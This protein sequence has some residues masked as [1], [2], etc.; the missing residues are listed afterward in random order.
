M[1]ITQSQRFLPE[2]SGAYI[3]SD[4]P[5]E[6][7]PKNSL[8]FSLIIPTYNEQGN[9]ERIVQI[10]AELLD[11]LIPEQYE[12]IIVDDN[13]PDGTAELAQVLSF[14]YPQLQVMC[15]TQERG[16]SS[17]V[18]R[19]WQCAQGEILG[20]IDGDLQHPPETLAKLLAAMHEG[21]DLALAS[22]HVEG[23]GVSSWSLIRRLLSRGAQLVGLLILP[24]VVGR[25]TDPM[26]GYFMVRRDAIANQSMNPTGY[27][28]LLEVLGRGNINQIIEVG[29]VFQER[30]EGESKVTSKQYFEYINHLLRL[31]S[32]GRLSKLKRRYQLPFTRFIRFALVGFSGVFVDMLM[33]YFLSDPSTLGWGLTR[34]KAISAEIAIFNNFLW[35]DLWT[36]GDLSKRQPGKR[37]RIKRFLKFNIICLAGLV[38]N[39]L[40]LNILFNGLGINR[41]AANLIAIFIVTLWNFWVN[42]KLGWRVTE[43]K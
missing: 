18:L 3:V 27:K 4:H 25:V 34:S 8:R 16:L 29:Y 14:Q 30:Q 41:Y 37:Q 12:L 31:R 17:A 15:R 23:G 6:I 42:L 5:P 35:N 38:L 21:A 2:P 26:S 9:I 7:S 40:I 1:T 10:L 39:I 11:S 13:S 20:V 28:I 33:F 43:I 24:N 32:R 36:F 22:R 19:G